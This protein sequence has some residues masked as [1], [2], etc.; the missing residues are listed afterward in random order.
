MMKYFYPAVCLHDSKENVF[1]VR[2]PDI[3]GCE[4]RGRNM[5]EATKKAREALAASLLEMEEKQ[6]YIPDATEERFLLQRYRNCQVCTFL[7]DMDDYRS[8]R[9]YKV[10]RAES[11]NAEWAAT[12]RKGRHQGFLARVFGLR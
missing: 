1:L 8:Y 5:G 11:T 9:E 7:V 2:F 4:A 6:L 3:P 12:V 10:K